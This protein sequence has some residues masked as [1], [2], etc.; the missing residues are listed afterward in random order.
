VLIGSTISDLKGPNFRVAHRIGKWS[1]P[2]WL[3]LPR[4]HIIHSHR[5]YYLICHRARYIC[6]C[7]PGGVLRVASLIPLIPAVSTNVALNTRVQ[8]EQYF[9]III[10][11]FSTMRLSIN[12]YN[13]TSLTGRHRFSISVPLTYFIHL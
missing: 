3:A 10:C 4:C 11:C 6:S 9:Y 8:T 12:Q 7:G 2:H 13:V 1:L 5:L